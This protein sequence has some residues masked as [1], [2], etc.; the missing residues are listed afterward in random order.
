MPKF[1]IGLFDFFFSFIRSHLSIIGANVYA[2]RFLFRKFFPVPVGTN[3]FPT[4]FFTISRWSD[5]VLR[6]L[7]DLE[8]TFKHAVK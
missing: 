3:K 2:T 1:L 7:I 8:L 6:S 4:F 5:F